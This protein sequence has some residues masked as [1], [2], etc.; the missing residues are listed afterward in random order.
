M[1]LVPDLISYRDGRPVAVVDAKYKDESPIPNADLYQ[2]LAYTT[3]LGLQHGHL[4]YANG[5]R[6]YAVAHGDRSA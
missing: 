2:L 1:Q 3:G 4:V 6:C 5:R